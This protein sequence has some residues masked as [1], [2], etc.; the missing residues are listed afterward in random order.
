MGVM[1]SQ[2]FDREVDVDVVGI[3]TG[4]S[5][6]LPLCYLFVTAYCTAHTGDEAGSRGKPVIRQAVELES[7]VTGLA[8]G[9]KL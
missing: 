5:G 3:V 7:L 9:G 1:E 4:S 6:V 2:V 8:E